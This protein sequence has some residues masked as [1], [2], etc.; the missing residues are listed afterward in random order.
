M[1]IKL[2]A[3]AKVN[4]CL[5]IT[6]IENGYHMLDTVMSSIDLYDTL[7][8]KPRKD[9]EIN[10][11]CE[12]LDPEQNSAAKAAMLFKD[13]FKTWGVDIEINKGIPF[14][15][16]LGGSSADAAGVLYGLCEIYG[17]DRKGVYDL[18]L[19][20]GSDTPYMINGGFARAQG[21]GEL[22]KPLYCPHKYDIV[23]AKTDKG[24][25]TRDAYAMFDNINKKI[26]KGGNAEN[27]VKALEER[28]FNALKQYCF[29]ALY[30]ASLTLLPELSLVINALND[31]GAAVSF[32]SGS[33]SACAGIFESDKKAAACAQILKKKNLFAAYVTTADKGIEII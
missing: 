33:G 31:C 7:Y 32:M 22:I 11:Y 16:G 9:E 26:N 28:D 25:N 30:N 10:C 17:I 20:C 2:K 12:G 23:I 1:D 4:F 13:K 3:R 29:N 19:S 15:S 6:G 18:A 8:I 21:R 14:C 24:V 27:V 5:E